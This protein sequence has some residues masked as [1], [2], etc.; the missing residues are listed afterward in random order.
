MSMPNTQAVIQCGGAALSWNGFNVYG[1]P[2]SIEEVKR[3]M[4]QDELVSYLR[5][6]L[7]QLEGGSNV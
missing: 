2:D 5:D 6:R 1:N 3:L 7:K 4:A